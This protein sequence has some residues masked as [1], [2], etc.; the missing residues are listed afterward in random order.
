[1]AFTVAQRDSLQAAIAS[2]V[3][4]VTFN[5]RTV[6]YHSLEQMRE[7]LAEMNRQLTPTTTRNYRL[8][9]FDK[10]V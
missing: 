9:A 10:G 1:M 6:T 7:L 5:N 4:T 2:G 8:A 3:Q